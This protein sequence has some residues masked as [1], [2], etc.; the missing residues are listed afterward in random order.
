MKKNN[1]NP[2][3]SVII[4]T[5]DS[6]R[7]IGSCLKT[8]KNQSYS[9]IEII[10]V[11]NFSNDKTKDIT[12]KYTKN[13][14]EKGPER[15]A[16]RNFGAEKA[17][18]KYLLIVDSDMELSENVVKECVKE[19]ESGNEVKEIIIPE[20]SFGDSFW[21]KCKALERSCYAGDDTI[22]AARF[23]DKET[24]LDFEGYDEQITG[25]EDWD[26]SQRIGKKYKISR[27]K[28]PIRH[29]EAD[30]SLIKSTRKKYYYSH[31]FLEYAKKHPKIAKKQINLIFRPAFF[32]NWK[33]L[34]KDPIHTLGFLFMKLCESIAGTIGIIVSRFKRH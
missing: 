22:E 17:K 12:L 15:S 1:N 13:F 18:G 31:K 33:R 11:D 14:F 19:I 34:I 4:T 2:L 5:K 25:P 23:F 6:E 32:R 26:L 29:N 21:A 30:L 20:I 28:S 8:I 16:Q 9:N 24:F 10:V 27:I 7:F 3:V